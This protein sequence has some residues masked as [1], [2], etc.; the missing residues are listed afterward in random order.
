MQDRINENNLGIAQ[1]KESAERYRSI[2]ERLVKSLGDPFCNT[3]CIPDLMREYTARNA[4]KA[5]EAVGERVAAMRILESENAEL[6]MTIA[7]RRLNGMKVDSKPKD[8]H[9]KCLLD[10]EWKMADDD[11]SHCL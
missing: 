8:A 11:H 4:A 9:S 3:H 1:L 6:S 10:P 5:S 7:E 2:H